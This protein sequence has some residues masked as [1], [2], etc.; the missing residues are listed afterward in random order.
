MS[1]AIASSSI[2]VKAAP[3]MPPASVQ[4][5]LWRLTLAQYHEMIRTGILTASDQVELLEG[6]L[7]YKMPKNPPHSLAGDLVRAALS[8]VLPIGWHVKAQDP[9]TLADSDSEPEPDLAIVRGSLRDYR[10]R[11]AGAE[12]VALVVEVSD[13]TLERDRSLKKRLYARAGIP[14][15]WIINLVE[16]QVEVFTEPSGFAEAPD[17]AQR[18]EYS[19]TEAVPV[20]I[21]KREIGLIPVREL[22]P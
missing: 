6:W 7:V 20:L 10:D 13:S 9:I 14:V 15:Y 1:V 21:E 19:L 17:Y 8:A 22:L 4:D 16:R 3:V 18:Y 2:S 11:H 5:Y 12:D